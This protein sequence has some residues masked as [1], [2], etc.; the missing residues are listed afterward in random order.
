MKP[1]GMPP[2]PTRRRI[3]ESLSTRKN[4]ISDDIIFMETSL[5]NRDFRN[6]GKLVRARAE[7]RSINE[8]LRNSNIR[9]YKKS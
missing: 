1:P 6:F 7:L 8:Q 9:D 5:I 2:Y 3:L 4:S